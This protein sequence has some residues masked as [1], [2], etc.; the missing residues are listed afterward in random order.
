MYKSLRYL[1]YA[2]GL[3][4]MVNGIKHETD[5][6]YRQI[7]QKVLPIQWVS[8]KLVHNIPRGE[9]QFYRVEYK[10]AHLQKNASW[11]K[12]AVQMSDAEKAD[13]LSTVQWPNK[14][15]TYEGTFCEA[16]AVERR[17]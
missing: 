7:V 5:S 11:A 8:E 13:E 14:A 4:V 9:N 2:Q 15:D 3:W 17:L 6:W 1:G 12:I 10:I 16:Q